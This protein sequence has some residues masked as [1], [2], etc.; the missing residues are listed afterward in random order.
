MVRT[1]YI[2]TDCKQLK[3]NELDGYFEI[4]RRQIVNIDF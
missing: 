4:D 3:Y 1:F 2:K